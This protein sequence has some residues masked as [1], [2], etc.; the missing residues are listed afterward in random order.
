ML[1]VK[2]VSRHAGT[3][4]WFEESGQENALWSFILV[5]YGKCVYWLEGEKVLLEKGDVLLIP[6]G[7]S[8]YGKSIPSLSHEKYVVTFAVSTE[9]G[10]ALP[11][12]AV[13]H[14]LHLRSTQADLLLGRIQTMWEEWTEQFPYREAMGHALLLE[15]LT[16]LN[17]E[18]DHGPR[19]SVKHRQAEAMKAYIKNHYREKVTKDELAAAI[20]KSPNYAATLFRLT[21]GQ[22]ISDYVH[23]MRI[24]T[25]IYMLRHSQLTVGD[26]A[27]YLGYCDTSYFHRTFR[28]LTGASPSVYM[29]ERVEPLQ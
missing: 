23:T 20:G 16:R 27:D 9:T 6:A 26:I 2:S 28:R 21:T 8:F 12:T 25:A 22:T 19:S 17:R 14:P 10:L 3:M 4:P 15:M 24:K 13:T 5:G 29:K 18:W 7:T 11:I 1:S